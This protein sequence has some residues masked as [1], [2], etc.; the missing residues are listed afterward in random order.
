MEPTEQKPCRVLVGI[1]VLNN[2]EITRGC[3]QTLFRHTDADRVN[4]A[5]DVLIVDN[6]SRD[7]IAG[8]LGQEFSDS[9]FPLRYVRNE[10]NL[11]VAVAW[12]QILRYSFRHMESGEF[13]YDFY[14]ISNNDVFFGP[15]WL[16]PMVE[17]MRRDRKIGWLS[18]LENGSPVLEELLE[19]HSLSKK[20]RIDPRQ[21]YTTPVILGSLDRIYG[22][23][24][25][26]ER[27]C[28]QVRERSLPDFIPFRKEGRSAVCFM[29]RPDMVRQIGYFDEDFPPVGIAEDLEYFLRIERVLMPQWLTQDRYPEKD[30]WKCGF[31]G[32][33]VVHHHWCSTHQGPGF[34]GRKWDQEREKN[35]QTKFGRSKKYYTSLLP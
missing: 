33:S 19:A 21:P 11:G 24:G 34:D 29:L 8:M 10:T 13:E 9:R 6:G 12:N 16:Q 7:D 31:S 1:P 35:W 14:V 22:K 26:H 4:L 20:H 23:W 5:V 32:K 30:K 25:G 28:R 17:T 27:F 15:D 18:V 2:L 3:L